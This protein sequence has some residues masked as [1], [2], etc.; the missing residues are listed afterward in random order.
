MKILGRGFV[1]GFSSFFGLPLEEPDI[2]TRG[3]YDD[4]KAL[5]QDWEN[6]GRD[7][8]KAIRRFEKEHPKQLPEI[9]R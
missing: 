7:M 1:E 2:S 5:K 8:E 9:N 6:V 4:H 3:F